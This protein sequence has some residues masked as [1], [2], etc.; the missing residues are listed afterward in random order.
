MLKTCMDRQTEDIS[1]SPFFFCDWGEKPINAQVRGIKKG[2]FC[3]ML[4]SDLPVIHAVCV[5]SSGLFKKENCFV[6]L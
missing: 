4:S 5:L 2:G 6:Y 1:T 3:K